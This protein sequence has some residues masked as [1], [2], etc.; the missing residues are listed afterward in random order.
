MLGIRDSGL[1]HFGG[2]ECYNTIPFNYHLVSSLLVG[3][4]YLGCLLRW[5]KELINPV[6]IPKKAPNLVEKVTLVLGIISYVYTFH[7]KL[8]RKQGFF[9]LNPCHTTILLQSVLLLAP[10]NTT[11]FMK[12][13]HTTWSGW[14]FGA[15]GAFIWPHLEGL[16][17]L[18][19]VLYYCE[20]L[21]ILPIGSIVLHRR[22]GTLRPNFKN[23]ILAF[24][25][26]LLCQVWVLTP[27]SRIFKVNINFTLCASPAEPFWP[28]WGYHYFTIECFFCNFVSICVR[29]L[30]HAYTSLFCP[31]HK[32]PIKD[33]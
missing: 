19:I 7:M 10:D 8:E 26:L 23:C 1:S 22:Y 6:N 33:E 2:E 32:E 21:V 9:M 4:L 28:G 25:V 15:F 30:M 12:M 31:R 29:I 27:L 17:L 13:L 11:P 16:S 20:H 5:H 18:E 3:L 24:S 14:A